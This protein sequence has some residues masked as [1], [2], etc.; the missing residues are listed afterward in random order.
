MI[1]NIVFCLSLL[2]HR[3]AARPFPRGHQHAVHFL[4]GR[5]GEGTGDRRPVQP[6]QGG[7]GGPGEAAVGHLWVRCHRLSRRPGRPPARP[8]RGVHLRRLLVRVVQKGIARAHHL[9]GGGKE[10][11]NERGKVVDYYSYTG[12]PCWQCVIC[13]QGCDRSKL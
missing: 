10:G 6:V 3:H 8:P 7:R 11:M 2:P 12:D 4:H 13:Q 5:L 1:A 9:R